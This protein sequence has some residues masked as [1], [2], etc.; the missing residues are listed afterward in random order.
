M[1]WS[2]IDCRMTILFDE[3]EI[4]REK[5]RERESNSLPLIIFIQ[6]SMS[7]NLTKFDTLT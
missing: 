7:L 4:E 2:T 1:S 5:K 6:N 3:R